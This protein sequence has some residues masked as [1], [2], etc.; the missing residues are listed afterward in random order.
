MKLLLDTYLC[1]GACKDI[2]VGGY[3]VVWAP[4]LV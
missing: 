3:D 4:E 1:G 2:Q